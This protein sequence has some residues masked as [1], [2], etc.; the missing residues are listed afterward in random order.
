MD[1]TK[2]QNNMGNPRP[3]S[4]REE[5]EAEQKKELDEIVGGNERDQGK[6]SDQSN[7]VTSDS[8]NIDN[9]LQFEAESIKLLIEKGDELFQ[10]VTAWE[11]KY[12]ALEEDMEAAERKH[13][14][15]LD[16][17]VAGYEAQQQKLSDQNTEANLVT[18]NLLQRR[19]RTPSVPGKVHQQPGRETTELGD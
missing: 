19:G 4:L 17:V 6:L 11:D 14:Q 16:E 3:T 2:C 1:R 12:S 9:L 5:M 15:R 10:C 13:K 7:Q 18:S 8:M